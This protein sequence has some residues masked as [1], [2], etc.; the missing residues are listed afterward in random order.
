[1]ADKDLLMAYSVM[2]KLYMNG[3]VKQI[4][5]DPA[6]SQSEV[7]SIEN[8]DE[9]YVPLAP[10]E[11]DPKLFSYAYGQDPAILMS[12]I[13]TEEGEQ[14]STCANTPWPPPTRPAAKNGR[15]WAGTLCCS[16]PKPTPRPRI[17]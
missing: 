5:G 11:Q 4:R 6:G 12:R 16:T 14:P 17:P 15:S 1:M 2:D 9:T 3:L 7:A 13:V 8:P 10:D